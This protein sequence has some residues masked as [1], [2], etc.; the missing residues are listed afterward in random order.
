[1]IEANGFPFFSMAIGGGLCIL[2][3]SILR[4]WTLLN[5]MRL[6]SPAQYIRN[7]FAFSCL[8]SLISLFVFGYLVVLST[9]IT[10]ISLPMEL[11]FGWI[12]FLGSIFVL[13]TANV[14][15]AVLRR[16]FKANI[17]LRN[18]AM[19]D[20]M[21]GLPNRRYI[22]EKLKIAVANLPSAP[23]AL[24]FVDIIGFK[25]VNNSFA[26]AVG[27]QI[28]EQL[29]SRLADAT[30][31]GEVA[32]R[33]GGDDFAILLPGYSPRETIRRVREIK[34]VL[35]KEYIVGNIHF[36][37]DCGFGVY[38]G[39]AQDIRPEHIIAKANMAMMHSKE[40]G[41]N[42]ISIFSK[43]MQAKA[44]HTI[45]FESQFRQSLENQHFF[46]VFQP[47][48]ALSSPP[49]LVGFEVLARW[50]H[51]DRGMISP[52]EFIPLAEATGLILQLDQYVLNLA[53]RTWRQMRAQCPEC[54]KLHFSVNLSAVHLDRPTFLRR[55]ENTLKKHSIPNEA[56]TLEITESAL[57]HSPEAAARKMHHLH[58][59]GIRVALDDFGTG[60]SSLAYLTRF[61]CYCLKIDKSFV[62][63]ITTDTNS[64]RVVRSII[65]LA[66][67]LGLIAL[68]EGVETQEQLELL[69]GLG[70][71]QIQGFYLG[72]PIPED[73][74][75]PLIKEKLG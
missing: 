14:T 43:S 22:V 31:D 65:N 62:D 42:R 70:C 58:S 15:T 4:Y 53:C 39:N 67:G 2:V 72:R 60:Y 44:H 59:T 57:M 51:P 20:Y 66:H 40:R 64:L 3:I 13:V 9:H 38:L 45:H 28:L 37:L 11:V 50:K 12:L 7:R 5:E 48:Y 26:H 33:L 21:T 32:A 52:A 75:L 19:H 68:A 69:K 34:R 36:S 47:Q 54:R 73:E 18:Q 17:V 49:A 29:S 74:V 35:Q 56:I 71:D 30:K 46:L 41:R 63:N 10:D 16:V 25:R 27:D 23:Y 8:L 6:Q 55:F 24:L 61:P 1:M